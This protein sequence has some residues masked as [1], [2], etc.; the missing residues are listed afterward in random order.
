MYTKAQYIQIAQHKSGIQCMYQDF[1]LTIVKGVGGYVVLHHFNNMSFS[2]IYRVGHFYLWMK[3]EYPEKTPSL[4]QV[5]DK[6][7]HIMFYRHGW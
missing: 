6:L 5:T 4:S 3:P 1:I 2:A 7:Y